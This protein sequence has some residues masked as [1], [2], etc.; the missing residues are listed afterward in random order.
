M[1]S[2]FGKQ[3]IDGVERQQC[4]A[5]LEEL[6]EIQSFQKKESDLYDTSVIK[7]AGSNVADEQVIQEMLK[8]TNRLIQSVNE[9]IEHLRGISPI[10]IAVSPVWHAWELRYSDY[11]AW[12]TVQA[13]VAN[14][15][16]S[17]RAQADDKLKL[18]NK[19]T[20]Q[21]GKSLH[22]AIDESMQ[23]LKAL[24]LNDDEHA[25]LFWIAKEAENE[26]WQSD[27]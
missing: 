4:L 3:K 18:L 25:R 5:C 2:L 19:L 26:T 9:S 6:W 24:K 7:F 27:E 23:L 15:L 12:A 11:L 22:K 17:N 13:E 1:G 14:A 20:S 16:L 10:P 8:V 21:K